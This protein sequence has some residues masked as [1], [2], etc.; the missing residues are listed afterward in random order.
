MKLCSKCGH[1]KEEMILSER[2]YVCESPA[3]GLVINRDFNAALNLTALVKHASQPGPYREFL[4]KGETS[5][6]RGALADPFYDG[7]FCFR[8]C[9]D[10]IAIR[11][12]PC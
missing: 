7:S 8:V 9:I 12:H 4:G 5:V 11:H 1:I 6:E 3:C 2:I 10:H